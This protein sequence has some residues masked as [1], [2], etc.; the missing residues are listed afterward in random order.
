MDG[1][2]K[3]QSRILGR[4]VDLDRMKD[5]YRSE[6][7]KEPR[8]VSA[9][10]QIKG[11]YIGQYEF[12]GVSFGRIRSVQSRLSVEHLVMGSDRKDLKKFEQVKTDGSAIEKMSEQKKGKSL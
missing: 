11:Y 4:F 10:E 8:I 6:F 2:A 7:K 9:G 5:S 12:Q 3:N 1:F